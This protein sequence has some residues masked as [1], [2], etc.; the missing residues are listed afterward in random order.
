MC[1]ALEGKDTD[2]ETPESTVIPQSIPALDHL[3]CRWDQT[4]F[5]PTGQS[6]EE[7][8]PVNHSGTM[9][10]QLFFS[11]AV[12][13]RGIGATQ[14]AVQNGAGPYTVQHFGSYTWLMLAASHGVTQGVSWCCGAE[15]TEFG[16][17]LFMLQLCC[18]RRQ[19]R[20]SVAITPEKQCL[21]QGKA[22]ERTG[23]DKALRQVLT[24]GDPT[25]LLFF[26][27]EQ[28]S[29][30]TLRPGPGDTDVLAGRCSDTAFTR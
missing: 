25:F 4:G 16:A 10:R 17:S 13:V 21:L 11:R 8:A 18:P 24:E 15:H 7:S 12:G 19:S 27:N 5:E 22:K 20:L 26:F 3:Y 30:G 2:N 23:R 6:I 14:H 1:C 9:P 28:Q 29:A